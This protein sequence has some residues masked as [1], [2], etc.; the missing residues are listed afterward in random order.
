MGRGLRY[1]HMLRSVVIGHVPVWLDDDRVCY[2]SRVWG[3]RCLALAAPGPDRSSWAAAQGSHYSCGVLAL[4]LLHTAAPTATYCTIKSVEGHSEGEGRGGCKGFLLRIL[5]D[6][7]DTVLWKV[8]MLYHWMHWVWVFYRFHTKILF[9]SI[10]WFGKLLQ[11]PWERQML[12]MALLVA[13]WSIHAT[14]L[15]TARNLSQ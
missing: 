5:K 8:I 10:M 14:L 11:M 13:V 2:Q 15:S 12:W 7:H 3:A 4:A 6:G 1:R 9:L